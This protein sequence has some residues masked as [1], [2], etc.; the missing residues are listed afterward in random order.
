MKT[1]QIIE[2]LK[3]EYSAYTEE[4]FKVWQILF[5]RQ[6]SQ[7]TEFADD[8]YLK[9]IKD[10]GFT[11]DKIPD[12]NEVNERLIQLTGWSIKVVP[13]IISQSDFFRMLA[14]K[15]FPSSTWLRSYEELD[16]LSEPDM[17]HDA[18]GHMPLLTN[19]VF[20]DFF[21]KMGKL[22][23]KYIDEPKI[24]EKLGRI[25]W[26]TVEF[27]LI[28]RENVLKIYGAGIISSYGESKYSL[29]E[30]PIKKPYDILEVMNTDFDNT[31]IQ[32]LYFV[33]SSFEELSESV[34]LAQAEFERLVNHA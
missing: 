28:Q 34:Q 33:I 25:Y 17:F 3:Q 15:I 22:G 7:L 32:E 6:Y 8:Y 26:F 16:Y 21:Q 4:D 12:F 20:C 30:A 1:Y 31:V 11:A 5:D 2:G 14:E 19:P 10:I 9:G 24:I 23:L 13:G 18:F 29:S 27:G